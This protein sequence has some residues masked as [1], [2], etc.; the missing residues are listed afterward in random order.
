MTSYAGKCRLKVLLMATLFA[1]LSSPARGQVDQTFRRLFD[2]ILDLELR[3][4]VFASAAFDGAADDANA[5]ITPVLNELIGNAISSLPITSTIAGV[6]FDLSSGIPRINRESLGPIFSETATTVGR[7]KLVVGLN[8]SHYRLDALRGLQTSDIRFTFTSADVNESGSI[9][10]HIYETETIDV[11]PG[12][13]VDA[14]QSVFFV[15]YGLTD[16][17]DAGIAVPWLRLDIE[18]SARAVINSTSLYER[19]V[20][21]N[22]FNGQPNTP[23]LE[24][25]VPYAESASGLGDVAARIKYAVLRKSDQGGPGGSTGSLVDLA[26]LAEFRA[27]ISAGDDSEFLRLEKPAAKITLAASKGRSGL[28]SH[29]NLGYEFRTGATDSDKLQFFAGF[30]RGLTDD[31]GLTVDLFALF[32]IE[33]TSIL[34]PAPVELNIE[35]TGGLFGDLHTMTLVERTNIDDRNRDNLLALSVGLKA[36]AVERLSL[37]AN[38]FIALN[39][40][41]LRSSIVPTFGL[42]TYL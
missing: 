32:D 22:S 18:G 15:T 37:L 16:R 38:V 14:R 11:Y 34:F 27:P 25:I 12:F 42:S 7:R 28:T 29:V 5:F 21:F 19:G 10:D 24:T 39:D 2:R 8:H 3:S 31:I 20:A 41:G 35:R 36:V 6:T 17:L 13:R 33:D 30:E 4:E 1:S 26:V 40:A 9:G 23:Q